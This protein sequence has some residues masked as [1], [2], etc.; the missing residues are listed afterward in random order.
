MDEK[1]KLLFIVTAHENNDCVEDTIN[2]IKKFNTDVEPLIAI[3]TSEKF[4]DFDEERFSNIQYLKISVCMIHFCF[5][6]C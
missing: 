1:V 4:R 5:E 3:H 2:N 6:F